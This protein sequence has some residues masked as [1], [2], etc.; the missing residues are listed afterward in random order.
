MNNFSLNAPVPSAPD[1]D[2]ATILLVDADYWTYQL[3]SCLQHKAPI[4]TV[5]TAPMENSEG[6]IFHMESIGALHTLIDAQ[7]RGLM[8]AFRSENI[9]VYIQG[10]GNFREEIAVTKP[11]KGKRNKAKPIYYQATRDYLVEQYD[12]HI[13]EGHETDDEVCIRQAEC[14]DRGIP[15]VIISPDKD[16]KNMVGYNYNPVKKVLTLIT[17]EMAERHMWEQMVIGDNPVD[18][19]PGVNRVGA[20]WVKKYAHLDNED[21]KDEVYD[22]Y[23]QKHDEI[24]MVEQWRLLHMCRHEQETHTIIH[25]MIYNFEAGY[26]EPEPI[27]YYPEEDL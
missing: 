7:V 24:Y 15:S 5:T 13:V 21:F 8:L 9:E 2:Q 3:S 12:A 16:L 20:A 23:M 25:P 18:N 6:E 19:I 17:P 1:M 14:M 26:V 10:T 4:G 27:V 11:Y 22:L